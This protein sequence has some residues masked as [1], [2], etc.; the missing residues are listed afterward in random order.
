MDEGGLRGLRVSELPSV[1]RFRGTGSPETPYQ[2]RA[3]RRSPIRLEPLRSRS[4]PPEP[5]FRGRPKPEEKKKEEALP[6][7]KTPRL[8]A[9]PRCFGRAEQVEDLAATLCTDPP[10]PTPILGPPGVGKT[11]ITLTALHDRRVVEKYGARRYFVRCDG[12]KSRDALVGEI[13]TALGIEPGPN[14]EERIFLDLER[15]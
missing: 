9:P 6:E 8:P 2:G 11:T 1:P 14:L 15:A 3:H 13:I 7:S 10:P 4:L 12:A 5:P